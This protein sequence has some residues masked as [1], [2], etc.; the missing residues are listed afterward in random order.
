[1]W[2]PEKLA[3]QGLCFVKSNVLVLHALTGGAVRLSF[4]SYPWFPCGNLAEVASILTKNLLRGPINN[5]MTL[6]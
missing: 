2:P 3:N 6:G 4:L 5:K 1:M